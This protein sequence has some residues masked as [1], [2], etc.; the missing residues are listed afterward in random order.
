MSRQI[1]WQSGEMQLCRWDLPPALRHHHLKSDRNVHYT[2]RTHK[3]RVLFSKIK[4]IDPVP[5]LPSDSMPFPLVQRRAKP[6]VWRWAGDVLERG[7]ESATSSAQPYPGV[8]FQKSVSAVVGHRTPLQLLWAAKLQPDGVHKVDGKRKNQV[9]HG[10]NINIGL[11]V[12][13]RS[14]KSNPDTINTLVTPETPARI[15]RVDHSHKIVKE[16]LHQPRTVYTR[17]SDHEMNKKWHNGA[18]RYPPYQLPSPK[19]V[20]K[21][22]A[23]RSALYLA[24]CGRGDY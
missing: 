16:N 5:M 8:I 10:K 4:K 6:E 1:W 22:Q 13:F 24:G 17:P 15:L 11:P 3:R 21:P 2:P 14:K 18:L 20:C 12:H 23:K 19:V 9:S 7:C